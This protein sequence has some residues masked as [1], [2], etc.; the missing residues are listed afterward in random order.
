MP[1]CSQYFGCNLSNR[2]VGVVTDTEAANTAQDSGALTN[3]E[4][5]LKNNPFYLMCRHHRY[6]SY[7]IMFEMLEY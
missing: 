4:K 2:I 1:S 3:L 6:R 7:R 5:Y